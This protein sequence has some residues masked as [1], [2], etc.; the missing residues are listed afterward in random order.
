MRVH[1]AIP[2]LA[3]VTMVAGCGDATGPLLEPT[4]RCAGNGNA[5]ASFA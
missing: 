1:G 5:V 2:L 4:E 3:A